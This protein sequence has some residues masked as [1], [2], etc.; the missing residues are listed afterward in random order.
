MRID[1]K[2]GTIIAVISVDYFLIMASPSAPTNKFHTIMAAK[3]IKN[4]LGKPKMFLGG[5]FIT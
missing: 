5:I 3:Y 1:Y 2:E 4:L